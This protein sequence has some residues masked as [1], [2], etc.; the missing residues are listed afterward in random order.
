MGQLFGPMRGARLFVILVGRFWA[1]SPD[2]AASVIAMG[3][4]S[5]PVM[6]RYGYDPRCRPASSRRQAPS[7]SHPA[8]AGAVVL[9]DPWA[10]RSA[11][12]RRRLHPSFILV[13]LFCGWIFIVSIIWPE[14]VRR[15]Q[16]SSAPRASACCSCAAW[17]DG[18]VAGADLHG[19][20]HHPGRP[21]DPDRGGAM[22]ASAH[23]RSRS[24]T[25][26]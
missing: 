8:L 20:R 16:G 2:V 17:F 6:S 12:L 9:A 26:G 4:I 22:G 24:C 25:A 23:W 11:T 5:L 3:L 14:K 13:G 7:P 1:R 21:C 10:S 18:A 19:A 15:C